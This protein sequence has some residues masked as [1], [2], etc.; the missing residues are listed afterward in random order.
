MATRSTPSTS[1]AKRRPKRRKV[2]TTVNLEPTVR[3]YL[4]VLMAKHDRDRSYLVNALIKQHM[5]QESSA[6]L[7]A[8]FP[9]TKA[10]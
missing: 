8:E 1:S 4:D 7:P 5:R 9:P 3:A 6:D 2:V 10:D